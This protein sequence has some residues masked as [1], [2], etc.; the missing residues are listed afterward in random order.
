MKARRHFN[1]NTLSHDSAAASHRNVPYRG[2]GLG[3]LGFSTDSGFLSL[4]GPQRRRWLRDRVIHGI[5]AVVYVAGC[6]ALVWAG[7]ALR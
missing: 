2:S 6:A 7:S 4:S 3:E 1:I 5:L